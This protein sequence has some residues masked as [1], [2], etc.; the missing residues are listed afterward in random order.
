MPTW[1]HLIMN[2]KNGAEAAS[3]LNK[4]IGLQNKIAIQVYE[5]ATYANAK[6]WQMEGKS[7]S[8][9]L[10]LI[11]IYLTNILNTYQDLGKKELAAPL[12]EIFEISEISEAVRKI[13]KQI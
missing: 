3:Y 6:L 11:A 10:E 1:E 7:D 4:A 2:W 9:R 5:R 12:T 13:N 8:R